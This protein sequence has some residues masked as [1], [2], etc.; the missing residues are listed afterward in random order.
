MDLPEI[1]INKDV[2]YLGL[3]TYRDRNI[4]FG[5]KRKDRRQHVYILGKSGTGKSVLMFNMIIQNIKNG[6]G[7]CVV[8]PHGELVEGVLSAI[9][10]HRMK[11]VVYFNPADTDYHIGFNVLELIDPQYKHLVA[12]GLMGIFTK[13]WANAWSARMEYILNNC[14]LALLDTPGTTLLGIPRM[15][16][17]KDYRQK[18]ISNLKDPVI[19]AFWVHEYEA[20]QDKFRNEAIAPIQ[21]K[22][23]QFLSTSIIRNVVGQSKS[24]INIFDIMNDGK[25]FLVNVSKGRIGEDNSSLLGGMIITKIQLAAM[26][27]VRIPEEHRK[28]FYLY[29][30]EFQNFVTDAFAGILSEARKYRLNLTVAHQYTAQLV[31][32]KSSAV[33]DAVFGNVGTMIVFRVGSDDADFLESEFDPEFTPGDIVNLPNYKV[34][35]KLMI[36]GV[37]SRPFSAKTLPQMV[38][39]GDKKV[40][41]EVIASSRALY[42]KSKEVV[43]REINNWSGMSLG[44]DSDHSSSAL[45]KF[46][47]TCSLCKKET[48]VPFK[49]EP[50]RAV[51]CKDCIAKIKSGEV[52]VEKKGEDQ[53][54][55]DE[56]KFFKPLA[57]LGI[58]FKP[59]NEKIEEDER[60]PERIDKPEHDAKPNKI[61]STFKKVF[62]PSKT[63]P[64]I[65]DKVHQS[66]A[67]I[68]KP[69]HPAGGENTALREVLNK[70]LVTP[71]V[72]EPISL[73]TLHNKIEEEAKKTVHTSSDYVP[74]K[75][76]A[77][78]QDEM[79]KLKDLIQEK[80]P[81]PEKVEKKEE[82]IPKKP[83]KEVPEDVLRKI[84][85]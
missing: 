33:R 51:Y 26:E 3:T 72:P 54:K 46:P 23:G 79:N 43:E 32:D 47:V 38:K 77:A 67:P 63:P 56:S 73:E 5:I 12:S 41:E 37:T 9:P 44:N 4:L 18:I 78:S 1:P 80:V 52:K 13:I 75:D 84:L 45:E 14:I 10:P 57:D 81:T 76:R 74:S 60:Y 34:Y 15:L 85:E 48:T 42:C 16:V 70:T 31:M 65:P 53:I 49:P 62:T 7:V 50:G 36:D 30:D 17:D 61:I 22:V 68:K 2:T 24:T 28:D 58:E 83:T 27:R 69:F 20:W 71:P 11:D 35:L 66:P 29:V 19:K 64:K 59:K 40:E 21:N 25:I 6:E 82:E 39:S 8:D 55:Y